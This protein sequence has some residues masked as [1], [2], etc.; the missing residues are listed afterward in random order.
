MAARRF[1]ANLY[2]ACGVRPAATVDT[3]D[4]HVTLETRSW[5]VGRC[6]LYAVQMQNWGYSGG[7]YVLRLAQPMHIY[8]LNAGRYLGRKQSASFPA[9]RAR[10]FLLAPA[11][12]KAIRAELADDSLRPGDSVTV[13]LAVPADNP[14]GPY[15]AAVRLYDPGGMEQIWARRNPVLERRAEITL[16]LGYN[17]PGGTWKLS[18]R[19]LATGRTQ[20]LTF[21]VAGNNP[22]IW[23]GC[24]RPRK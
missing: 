15:A 16:P 7:R 21:K 6:I 13:R 12:V 14:R 8:D 24:Y 10:F 19:D 2:R 4:I 5:R 3:D 17:A 9:R 1:I 20:T 11:Q 23:P 18:V 22:C